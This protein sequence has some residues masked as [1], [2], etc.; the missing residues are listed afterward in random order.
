LKI[1][2]WVSIQYSVAAS[3]FVITQFPSPPVINYGRS[4]SGEPPSGCHVNRVPVEMWGCTPLGFFFRTSASSALINY[5]R[6]ISARAARFERL[7]AIEMRGGPRWSVRILLADLHSVRPFCHVLMIRV[8]DFDHL[9]SSLRESI[10]R[11]PQEAAQIG[12][13][14]FQAETSRECHLWP[15]T[16]EPGTL[17]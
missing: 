9:S 6:S 13:S 17:R 11:N 4:I 8:S 1:E 3:L 14:Y 16:P 5:G 10:L 2:T 7:G 12:C 15:R